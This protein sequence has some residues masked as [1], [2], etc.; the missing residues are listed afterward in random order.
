MGARELPQHPV[1]LSPEPGTPGGHLV[2]PAPEPG[3][4]G[5]LPVSPAP[6]PSTPGGLSFSPA[7]L[8][9]LVALGIVARTVPQINVFIVGFPLQIA[10]GLVFLSLMSPVFVRLVQ[11]AL[12]RLGGEITTLLRLM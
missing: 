10:V 9:D 5:G 11:G 4:P 8:L 7:Q 1:S 3:T 12:S 6:K 2:S